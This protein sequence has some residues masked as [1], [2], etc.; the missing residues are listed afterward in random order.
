[1]AMIV[2]MTTVMATAIILTEMLTLD[3]LPRRETRG[4]RIATHP[5]TLETGQKLG[6]KTC[7]LAL[8]LARQRAAVS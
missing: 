1:M 8:L 4:V 5:E 7:L 3:R 2:V 6:L